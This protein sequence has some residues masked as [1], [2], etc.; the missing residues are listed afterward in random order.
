MTM[1]RALGVSTGAEGAREAK[2]EEEEEEELTEEAIAVRACYDELL[3][4]SERLKKV[5]T[6]LENT[7]TAVRESHIKKGRAVYISLVDQLCL[8]STAHE[9]ENEAKLVV[10]KGVLLS[11]T[12][13]RVPV[14][15]DELKVLGAKGGG[16]GARQRIEGSLAE[17]SKTGV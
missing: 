16:E 14:G 17:P 11:N 10:E 13:P 5:Q 1:V 15:K 6:K 8:R 7:A 9:I 12:V 2:E 4:L 3:A